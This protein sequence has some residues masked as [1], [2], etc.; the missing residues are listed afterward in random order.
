MFSGLLKEMKSFISMEKMLMFIILCGLIFALSEYYNTKS[1]VVDRFGDAETP[2]T[3]EQRVVDTPSTPLVT[4]PNTY[5]LQNTANPRDL[6][7]ADSNSEWSNLNPTSMNG[8][9][10]DLLTAGHHIGLDTIGQS[11]KNA[12]L[13]LRSDPIITKSET[14]PWNQS[15]IETDYSRTALELGCK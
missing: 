4:Q 7:P 5:G 12:N 10:P 6:L 9:M 1:L 3:T 14:G 8:E 11:L 15:T 2:S 13:Q